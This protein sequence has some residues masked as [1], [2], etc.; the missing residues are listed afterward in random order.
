MPQSFQHISE[1]IIYLYNVMYILQSNIINTYI[2]HI[3]NDIVIQY[4]IR[5]I[6]L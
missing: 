2:N 1:C 4:Y 6:C 3:T 5:Y